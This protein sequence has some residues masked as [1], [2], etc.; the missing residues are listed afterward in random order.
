MDAEYKDFEEFSGEKISDY[1]NKPITELPV[2]KLAKIWFTMDPKTEQE[3]NAYYENPEVRKLCLVESILYHKDCRFEDNA[4]LAVIKN[5]KPSGNIIDF[6][7]GTG[8]TSIWLAK[9]G[10]NVTAFD[11]NTKTMEFLQ[12]RCVKNNIQMNFANPNTFDCVKDNAADFIICKDVLEHLEDPWSL[13]EQFA[14]KLAVG[15]YLFLK[16]DF[17]ED[18][19]TAAFH[20]FHITR[21]PKEFC[22]R[23]VEMGFVNYAMKIQ[24]DSERQINYFYWK[25]IR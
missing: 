20:P 5:T 4:T 7:C 17:D 9:A 8:N 23:M 12:W 1:E 25:K 16:W 2:Y 13:I 21:K 11:L 24:T 6:G 19:Y 22:L 14:K 10:Y 18:E 15:G 3:R